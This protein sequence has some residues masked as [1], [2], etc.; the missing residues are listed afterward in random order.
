MLCIIM[1][2]GLRR[3]NLANTAF[4]CKVMTVKSFGLTQPTH[5]MPQPL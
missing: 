1:M 5:T 2:V 3:Q 4:T